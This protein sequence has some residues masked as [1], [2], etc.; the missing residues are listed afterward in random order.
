MS[1]VCYVLG[2]SASLALGI[3]L[4]ALHLCLKIGDKVFDYEEAE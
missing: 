4:L 1:D 3:Q 2:L